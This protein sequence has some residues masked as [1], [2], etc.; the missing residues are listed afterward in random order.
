MKREIRKRCG[1][2]CVICGLPFYEYD[3]I[4]DWAVVK[5]HEVDKITLL[6]RRHHGEKSAGLLPRDLVIRAN[7]SPHNIKSKI[8][9]AL[10]L[11]F[12]GSICTMELGN[13]MFSTGFSEA[14]PPMV[15]AQIDG[16]PI[17]AFRKEEN[18]LLLTVNVF[19]KYNKHV[20]QIHD[21]E[22]TYAADS[23][24]IEFVGTSLTIR[25]GIAKILLEIDFQ[26]PDRVVIPRG[27][28]LCNG[29]EILIEKDFITVSDGPKMSGI[30]AG[31]CSVLIIGYPMN[32]GI[33][34]FPDV[35]RYPPDRGM[36]IDKS[37]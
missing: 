31:N 16:I 23:Y 2:G 30:R 25:E 1:F 29:V 3:H 22:L 18:S 32:G 11:H 35:P 21:N 6:C 12:Y 17:L 34:V 9:S 26:T 27:R 19:N 7:S 15:V 14:S 10:P 33:F 4:E 8:S 20:L 28:L 37:I 5:R 36:T 24:D 13:N